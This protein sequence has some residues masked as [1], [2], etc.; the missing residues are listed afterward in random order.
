[1]SHRNTGLFVSG[2]V[3]PEDCSHIDL[4]GA[5]IGTSKRKNKNYTHVG[6]EELESAGC[7]LFD[8]LELPLS[9]QG[10]H[11]IA[12]ELSKI[13]KKSVIIFC[14]DEEAAGGHV[15]FEEGAIKSRE[16][17][18][19]RGYTPVRRTLTEQAQIEELDPSDWVW[20][21]IGDA[22]EQ[23]AKTVVGIG[24][25]DDDA[26]EKLMEDAGS[27]FQEDYSRKPPTPTPTTQVRPR[28]ER[29]SKLFGKIRSKIGS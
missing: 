26:I 17:I 10:A 13:Y 12:I 18:D 8:E 9:P 25:R 3:Q 5:R 14:D 29:L 6:L 11:H 27:L 1:M 28:R 7:V 21:F 16:I 24:I 22:I 2:H 23:G 4:S 19:G 15:L 20:P